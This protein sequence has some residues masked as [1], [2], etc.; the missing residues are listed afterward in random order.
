MK[1]GSTGIYRED[2]NGQPIYDWTIVD[3][4]FDTYLGAGLKPYVEIGFMP[5]ALSTHPQDY[6]HHPPARRTRL[7][8]AGQAYPPKDYA[9]WGEL[10]YQWAKH[11]VDRTTAQVEVAQWY[12]EVWNE[13]DIFLLAGSHA[14]V[15]Q[16]L[17]LRRGRRRAHAL[18]AARVGGTETAGG[19]AENFTR[20]FFEHCARGTNYA[21][22]KIGSPLDFISF[23][24]KGTIATY[25]TDGHVRMGMANQLSDIND[26]FAVVASFPE[27]RR[28]TPIVIGESDPEGCA[29]CKSPQNGYR[30]GTM[31]SSYTAASFRPRIRTGRQ[32]RRESGRCA[33]LGVRVRKSTAT[34]RGYRAARRRRPRSARPQRLPHVRKNER[35]APRRHQQPREPD[36]RIFIRRD[37]V[38]A[39][40]DVS[41][42]ASLDHNQ[43]CVLAW[44][45]HDDD[46][47]GP[48][49]DIALTLD[50]L[51]AGA[52]S[53]SL[54]QYRID[55]DHG[56][57]YAAWQ[58]L[59]SPEP[60]HC[61]P[62][63][64]TRKSRP[65]YRTRRA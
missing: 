59:G 56:N 28:T 54:T 20:E 31:Y 50:G 19:P 22:G 40:P 65:T 53:A 55:H 58:S 42:L 9:K 29:A 26:A 11:C 45:Y 44:H 37:G 64:S 52:A 41:A 16:A 15:F 60:T 33:D 3:R 18:P 30:N 13:A 23:H 43:L 49:A 62:I 2:A 12:W 14:G 10:V 17:R 61:R 39:E 47:P 32:Q 8:D 35:S 1:W 27:Y 5:E 6:P 46:L 63:R 24:A 25:V 38:R 51:P 48:A 21:T 7:A 36:A 4:I 34:S 57:S